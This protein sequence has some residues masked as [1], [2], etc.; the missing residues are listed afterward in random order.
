MH[1]LSYSKKG[2][3]KKKGKTNMKHLCMIFIVHWHRVMNMT[4]EDFEDLC[5]RYLF[6]SPQSKLYNCTIVQYNCTNKISK[7]KYQNAKESR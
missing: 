6:S 3:G 4:H 2:K 7:I 5:G 1:K